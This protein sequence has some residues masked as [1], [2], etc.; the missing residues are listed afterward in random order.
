MLPSVINRVSKSTKAPWVAIIVAGEISSFIAW[1]MIQLI[2]SPGSISALVAGFGPAEIFDEAASLCALIIY[3]SAHICTIVVRWLTQ[4]TVNDVI[5]SNAFRFRCATPT[6]DSFEISSFVEP[7]FYRW[8]GQRRVLQYLSYSQDLLFS[9][10]FAASAWEMSITSFFLFGFEAIVDLFNS[11]LTIILSSIPFQLLR[12][13]SSRP[14]CITTFEP[15]IWQHYHTHQIHDERDRW[16]SY[17]SP[18]HNKL[19]TYRRTHVSSAV[20]IHERGYFAR[21]HSTMR[22][23]QSTDHAW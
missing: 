20:Y 21:L 18:V 22:K 2:F 4:S 5:C 9:F 1:S 3:I 15:E 19:S 17:V 14:E 11:L 8:S 7:R 6:K 10:F 16:S 23:D 12:L 13:L